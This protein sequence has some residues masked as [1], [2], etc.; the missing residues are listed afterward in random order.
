MCHVAI[1]VKPGEAGG[2]IA[3]QVPKRLAK[4]EFFRQR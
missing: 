4:S 3:P 1:T 2:A